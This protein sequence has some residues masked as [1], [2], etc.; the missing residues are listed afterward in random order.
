VNILG[1]KNHFLI[2]GVEESLYLCM[3]TNKLK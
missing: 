1:N 3:E 2:F